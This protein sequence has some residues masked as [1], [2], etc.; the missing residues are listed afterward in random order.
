LTAGLSPQ[1]GEALVVVEVGKGAVQV[2]EV[3]DLRDV[4]GDEP[5]LRV[6]R[7]RADVLAGLREGE[8]GEWFLARGKRS[9]KIRHRFHPLRP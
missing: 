2:A 1:C 4:N 7:D 6:E 5:R 8:H 3:E 9:L